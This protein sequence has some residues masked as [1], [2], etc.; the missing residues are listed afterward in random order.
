VRNERTDRPAIS[1]DRPPAHAIPAAAPES[2][3]ES[4]LVLQRSAGNAAVA[5]MVGGRAAARRV[6][7]RQRLGSAR[8]TALQR[9]DVVTSK[10][11]ETT[12]T[13]NVYN[14]ELSVDK[15]KHRVQVQLAINWVKSGTWDSDETFWKFVR[16]I[17]TAVYGYVDN[18]F[19]MVVT[20][21][22]GSA[23]DFPIDF[24]LYDMNDG[25]KI[26]CFGK[27]HGG[28]EMTT[29]GGKLFELGQ[30]SETELPAITAAHEFGHA[31][32]GASDEYANPKVPG[33]TLTNDHS[34]M[35]NYYAQGVDKAEFKARHFQ[36]LVAEVAK[37]FPGAKVK[38]EK[39]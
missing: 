11:T 23:V 37:A 22:A 25:F 28:S 8:P 18:K 2:A 32:L 21:D 3:W 35:A 26:E 14:Q 7:A 24:L 34:I 31:L 1:A 29:D 10:V 33:R 38:L 6:P 19:K 30:A 27:Q 15:T 5:R 17:K 20:P 39:M 36:H 13:G 16:K 12:D 4:I 9:Q